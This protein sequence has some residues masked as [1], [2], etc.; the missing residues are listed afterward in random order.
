MVVPEPGGKECVF[1]YIKDIRGCVVLKYLQEC[2]SG[3]RGSM[4]T[5]KKL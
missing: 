5:L 3:S 2:M 4:N 1:Y